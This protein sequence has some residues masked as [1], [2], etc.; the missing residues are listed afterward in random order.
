MKTKMANGCPLG[1]EKL[2]K[3]LIRSPFFTKI[4][5]SVGNLGAK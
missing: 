3:W 4:A 5:K 2:E 1:I